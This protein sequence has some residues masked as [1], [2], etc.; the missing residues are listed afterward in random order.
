MLL[1]GGQKRTLIC[2]G[3][4]GIVLRCAWDVSISVNVGVNMGVKHVFIYESK[5][6]VLNIF[7]NMCSYIC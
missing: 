5:T 7:V 4:R 2:L 1:Y 3:C 6:L